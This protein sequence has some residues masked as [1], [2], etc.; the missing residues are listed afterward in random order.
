MIKKINIK[1]QLILLGLLLCSGSYSSH[2]E[3][4]EEIAINLNEFEGKTIECIEYDDE[5][6]YVSFTDDTEVS[7]Y[8]ETYSIIIDY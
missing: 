8:S 4:D 5:I 6:L 1:A 7:V 2:E 3:D